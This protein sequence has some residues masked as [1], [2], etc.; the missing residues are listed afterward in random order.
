[1]SPV[2]LHR[3]SWAF[4]LWAGGQAAWGCGPGWLR[5]GGAWVQPCQF[6]QAK[7][8]ALLAS[9]PAH[10]LFPCPTLFP[11][12]NSVAPSFLASCVFYCYRLATSLPFP[13]VPAPTLS[14]SLPLPPSL[15]LLVYCC[16]SL[17]LSGTSLLPFFTCLSLFFSLLGFLS[18]YLWVSV[19]HFLLR[20]V[21]SLV[22]VFISLCRPLHLSLSLPES[23]FPS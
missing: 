13:V 3:D 6:T 15:P 1:M 11:V 23:V 9:V 18:L 17:C 16:W 19:N 22:S 5:G 8:L 10:P 20:S 7:S 21:S 12:S 14:L 2:P 4:V